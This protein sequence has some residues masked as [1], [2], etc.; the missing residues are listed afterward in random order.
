MKALAEGTGQVHWTLSYQQLGSVLVLG[1]FG[2][3]LTKLM[4]LVE[5]RGSYFGLPSSI[6][7][8]IASNLRHTNLVHESMAQNYTLEVHTTSMN[9]LYPANP[10][11][12]I[13]CCFPAYPSALCRHVDSFWIWCNMHENHTTG[14]TFVLDS[15]HCISRCTYICRVAFIDVQTINV[16]RTF[17]GIFLIP[18]L[19]ILVTFGLPLYFLELSFGQFGST[20]P[21]SIWKAVPVFKG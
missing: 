6:L 14:I 3:F 11:R 16:C 17:A 1:T 21:I 4:M 8:W 7:I 15:I 5:V 19:V 13:K 2:G 10:A 12:M 18:C 20:G 9:R